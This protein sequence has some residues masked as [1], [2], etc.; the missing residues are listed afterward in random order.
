MQ[1]FLVMAA[2]TAVLLSFKSSRKA[3]WVFL[4]LLYVGYPDATIT[5]LLFG[6]GVYL[7]WRS[8]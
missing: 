1:D 6:G 8:K 2:L 5:A 3:G 4:A 7:Y